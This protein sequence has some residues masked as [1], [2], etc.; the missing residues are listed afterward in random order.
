ML[1]HED[2]TINIRF[3]FWSK[4]I[5]SASRRG[6]V[7]ASLLDLLVVLCGFDASVGC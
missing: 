7:D 5:S 2:Y 4:T 3:S 1:I 6:L